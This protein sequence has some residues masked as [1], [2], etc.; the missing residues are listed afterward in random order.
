[1]VETGVCQYCGCDVSSDSNACLS[2]AKTAMASTGRGKQ[3]PGRSA[4]ESSLIECRRRGW[5]AAKTEFWQPSF[6]ASS[7]IDAVVKNGDVSKAIANYKHFGPGVRRDIWGFID[8]L[9]IA[10]GKILAIQATTEPQASAHVL[11]IVRECAEPA[12]AWLK[13][14]GLIYVWGWS[15]VGHRWHVH[16]RP[17]ESCSFAG[18]CEAESAAADLRTQDSEDIPF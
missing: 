15:K 3:K 6:A 12:A 18:R 8:I 16:E 10:D 4:C 17:V 14:G 13:A 1:M 5:I 9:A 7:L 2:C 11:K